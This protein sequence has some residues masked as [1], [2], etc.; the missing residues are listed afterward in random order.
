M[1]SQDNDECASCERLSSDWLA[2]VALSR[3]LTRASGD[4]A[5]SASMA[6]SCSSAEQPERSKAIRP[7]LFA[8]CSLFSN[9]LHS[10]IDRISS[11]KIL[12]LTLLS[13]ILLHGA[14]KCRPRVLWPCAPYAH[15]SFFSTWPKARIAQPQIRLRNT[16][17][18]RKVQPSAVR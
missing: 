12:Y 7:A 1:R 9:S 14:L 17:D 6:A 11:F 18:G 4:G 15:S 16:Q 13:W 10:F 2:D 3:L 5:R 8:C